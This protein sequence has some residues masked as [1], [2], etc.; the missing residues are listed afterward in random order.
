MVQSRDSWQDARP[1]FRIKLVVLDDGE[2]LPFLVDGESGQPL[3]NPT[4]FV[5]T[6]YRNA[7]QAANT[8]EQVLRGVMLVHLLEMRQGFNLQHRIRSRV[9][10]HQNEI[11]ALA[12]LASLPLQLVNV[13]PPGVEGQQA[14]R[15][16]ARKIESI[17]LVRRLPTSKKHKAVS[18]NTKAIRLHYAGAYLKWL[19]GREKRRIGDLTFAQ[20]FADQAADMLRAIAIRT[21]PTRAR[22]REAIP[23]DERRRLVEVIDERSPDN[24]WTHPFVRMRN[25]L[26]ILW[27][28]GGGLRRGELLSMPVRQVELQFKRATILRNPDNARDPRRYQPSVKTRERHVPMGDELAV[29]TLNYI[30]ARSRIPAAKKHGFMFVT[31]AGAPMSMSALTK[32][33]RTLRERASGIS[34]SLTMHVLRHVW[35]EEFSDLVDANFLQ[36]EEETRIRNEAMGWSDRSKTAEKYQLRRTRAKAAEFSVEI[37][38]KFMR[39]VK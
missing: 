31:E 22:S 20:A 2:R 32:V 7:S 30:N 17:A 14:C 9:L 19:C 15:P 16:S 28:L 34:P 4:L 33:F 21:P 36:P 29:L 13:A 37:Q 3:F 5:V 25:R 11:D 26:I 35:N 24:P 12:Q 6:Q 23:P 1:A 8:I 39:K 27:G 10:L 18:A 38:D